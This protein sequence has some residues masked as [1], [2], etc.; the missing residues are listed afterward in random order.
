ML[1]KINPESRIGFRIFC[2][3]MREVAAVVRT[4]K[5]RIIAKIRKNSYDK[6][7]FLI[8]IKKKRN[9]L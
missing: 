5:I 3:M 9:L 7:M 6:L 8:I 2:F 1:H 4:T